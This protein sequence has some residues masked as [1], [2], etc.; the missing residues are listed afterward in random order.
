PREL[1]GKDFLNEALGGV[2]TPLIEHRFRE[3]LAGAEPDRQFF[4][5]I[6]NER[7]CPLRVKVHLKKALLDDSCWV[8]LKLAYR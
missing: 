4:L 7:L 1:I 5:T 3:V 6:L 2:Y 8:F